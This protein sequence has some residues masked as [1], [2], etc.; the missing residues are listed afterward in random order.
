MY[1]KLFL[2][3][4]CMAAL[5]QSSIA[6]NKQQD[7]VYLFS[8][9]TS[10]NLS[11]GG[12]HFAWSRDKQNWRS[13]GQEF[14]FLR[15]DYGNWG[16]QKK[17]F[18]PSLLLGPD[19]FWHCVWSVNETDKV[20]AHAASADLIDWG[21]Q[22]FPKINSGDAC[23]EPLLAYNK[24]TKLYSVFYH[25][26]DNKY[27]VVTSADLKKFS[28]TKSIPA[29]QYRDTRESVLVDGEQQ[30]G[31]VK[32]VAWSVVE[33]LQHYYE[34]KQF[35]GTE[36]KETIAKD[37]ET[38]KTLKPLT[39]TINL[40]PQNTKSISDMLIG[41][42]FE[43]LNYAADG[44]LYAEMVQNRDFEYKPTDKLTLDKNWNP[45]YAWKLSGENASFTIDSIKPIHPNNP[46]YALL[47]TTAA[48]AAL[49]NEGY[50]GFNIKKGDRYKL[51]LF[52]K[53]LKGA[54]DISV[55]L[56][57]EKNEVLAQ[58]DLSVSGSN[59]QNL[60]AVLV[61]SADNEH[62][63]L[64]IKPKHPGSI[65]FDLVSLF[66][67]S[68][69]KGRP[70]G[71]RA[72]L[73]QTIADIH[74]RFMRFPGG[75]LAHGDGL[76][77]MYRWKNSI[78]P[79]E[80]RLP[81]R[82]IWN[83][84]QT[85]GLG[86][87]EYFQFCEDIGAAPVP[88]IA[89]AVPCQNSAV[90][91]AGQQG[92][93]P[94]TE[95]GAYIQD[96]LDLIEYANGPATSKWGKVR[97]DEGHPQPFHLKYLGIGNEDLISDV[98]EERFTMIYNAIKKVHP[99]IEVIGTVGPAAE[100]TDYEQGWQ[101]ANKLKVPIVDEH[102]YQP[103]GWFINN[104][105]FYDGY[106]RKAS[107]VYLGEYAAHVPGR[108]SNVESA[109]TEALYLTNLERNADVVKMA[110]YAPLLAK[111]NHTQWTPDLIYFN[112][113]E[114]KPTVNYYVQQLFGEN[115]GN[116]Y[117]PNSFEVSD[118]TDNVRKRIACSVV[119]DGASGDLIIKIINLLPISVKSAFNWNGLAIPKGKLTQTTLTGSPTSETARPAV[120]TVDD[121]AGNLDLPAYSLTV[122]RYQQL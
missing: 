107:K 55:S 8:Y 38:Y 65:A 76:A 78:G 94:M 83:Y 103:P 116:S 75:C 80:S 93:L 64:Q 57:S 109:L 10:S 87:Y 108:K 89:A 102:Y 36:N 88:V 81:Q 77:N 96:I 60:K 91:G 72:D 119:R 4:G 3:I 79:L 19:D 35:K 6:A 12:L 73:A 113:R 110:S 34:A 105:D 100:G 92:G 118:N 20:F 99:E 67:E 28:P 59:W 32:K 68:T 106:D 40:Q 52:A 58:T 121:K 85:V 54:G 56:L 15:C 33:K 25:D 13:I 90:G 31:Q 61:P 7:S 101:L 42:F 115:S 30:T 49:V 21:R 71:L 70:N 24:Q 26:S 44:G 37:A 114:V 41:I 122:L 43:D 104:Q 2:A 74:P 11:R 111:E 95:M 53:L 45:S 62:A 27:F 66:P 82:N 112:N 117:V 18:S 97:A 23:L 84:H 98:F 22:N 120:K 47:N 16:T 63:V 29:S 9:T 86:Y 14:G 17:M 50:D 48:G 1:K 69:F 5:C 39:A 51:S 46:H